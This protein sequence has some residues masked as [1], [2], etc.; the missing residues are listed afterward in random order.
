MQNSMTVNPGVLDSLAAS[1][2]EI[3]GRVEGLAMLTDGAGRSGRVLAGS[4]IAEAVGAT[5]QRWAEE[6]D[7]EAVDV[8]DLANVPELIAAEIEAAE[9]S[10]ASRL[11]NA[12]VAAA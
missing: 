12:F 10:F 3:A 7:R 4:A 11:K 9:V 6:L 1:L 8:Y 2:R 5:A